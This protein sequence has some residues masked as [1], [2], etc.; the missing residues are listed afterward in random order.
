[1]DVAEDEDKWWPTAGGAVF[2]CATLAW[3]C[4]AFGG[5]IG[6]CT[7]PGAGCDDEVVT[8]AEAGAALAVAD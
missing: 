5:G 2:W 1:M 8:E 3:A 6:G 7:S 4:E